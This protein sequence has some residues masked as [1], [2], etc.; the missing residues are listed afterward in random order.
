MITGSNKFAKEIY[1]R[2]ENYSFTG[3]FRIVWVKKEKEK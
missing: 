3:Q 1:D 2:F